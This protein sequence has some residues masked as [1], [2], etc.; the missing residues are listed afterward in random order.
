MSLRYQSPIIYNYIMR[1]SY[2][3]L[4]NKKCN[5][6]CSYINKYGVKCNNQCLNKCVFI[7]REYFCEYHI[8][9]HINN[10]IK[11]NSFMSQLINM[12]NYIDK[13]LLN[14]YT[15]NQFQIE[16]IKYNNSMK[17]IYILINQHIDYIQMI[18]PLLD[19][20]YSFIFNFLQIGIYNTDTFKI[21]INIIKKYHYNYIINRNKKYRKDCIDTLLSLTENSNNTI[22]KVF[23]HSKIGDSN[24]FKIIESFI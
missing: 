12:T 11:L 23:L 16:K 5:N 22:G 21:N 4:L 18:Q 7:I 24:I 9:N 13:Y 2:N 14:S 20:L 17:K 19:I 6:K 15:L 3:K 8:T 10:I 1:I